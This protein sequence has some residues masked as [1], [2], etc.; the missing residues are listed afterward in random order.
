M[1]NKGF[2]LIEV[3]ISIAVL[4]IICVIFLQLFIKSGDIVKGSKELDRAVIVTNSAL[5]QI[6]GI[7]NMNK[8]Q[9]SKYFD[10][11][12][13]VYGEVLG[14]QKQVEIRFNLNS[15]FDYVA[16]N[17]TYQLKIT[18]EKENQS[19]MNQSLYRILLQFMKKDAPESIYEIRSAVI[20]N[21]HE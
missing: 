15:S 17:D 12:E 6:K 18:F 11:A 10:K 21:D 13:F 8:L 19:A 20:M 9:S 4:S 7:K 2:T 16:K 1:E 5:E 14:L 3:I